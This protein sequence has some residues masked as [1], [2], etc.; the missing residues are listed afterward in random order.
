MGSEY[1]LRCGLLGIV[2][3]IVLLVPGG[4]IGSAHSSV[5]VEEELATVN[6]EIEI[7]GAK[8]TVMVPGEAIDIEKGRK[9][10]GRDLENGIQ[11]AEYAYSNGETNVVKLYEIYYRLNQGQVTMVAVA[12]RESSEQEDWKYWIYELGLPRAV[13]KAVGETYLKEGNLDC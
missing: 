9:I 3:G 10:L 5:T 13:P 11:V 12:M 6:V 8:K 1:D 4:F 7:D 2:L